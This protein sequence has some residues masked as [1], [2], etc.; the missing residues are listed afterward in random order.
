MYLNSVS[1]SAP[2]TSPSVAETAYQNKT[3]LAHELK[4]SVKGE[5]S[6]RIRSVYVTKPEAYDVMWQKLES[7]YEDVGASVQ[8]ALEDLHKIRKLTLVTIAKCVEVAL[9]VT[10]YTY[11]VG[12]ISRGMNHKYLIF[13]SYYCLQCSEND[14]F[15]TENCFLNFK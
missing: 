6:R 12:E 7:F 13:I 10:Y 2:T 3:A 15:H 1:P 11:I 9:R 4:R 8:A 14:L 5:A